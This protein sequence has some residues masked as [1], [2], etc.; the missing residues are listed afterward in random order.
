MESR[1]KV[2]KPVKL[3]ARLAIALADVGFKGGIETGH[4]RARQLARCTYIPEED[5]RTMRAWFARHKHAS[6]PKYKMAEDTWL[7]PLLRSVLRGRRTPRQAAKKASDLSLAMSQWR[8]AIAWLLWGGDAALRWLTVSS[9]GQLRGGGRKLCKRGVDAAKHRFDKWPSAYASGHASQ[10][11]L[12]KI[13]GLDGKKRVDKKYARDTSNQKQEKGITGLSRWFKE[14]WV[15]VCTALDGGTPKPCGRSSAKSTR[16]FPYCR[17][18]VRVTKDT[19]V[20]WKEMER[21][22]LIDACNKKRSDPTKIMPTAKSKSGQRG[23]RG[24]SGKSSAK[25]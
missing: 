6:Y 18:S 3:T 24:K 13:K 20:T 4:R 17:P 7:G 25:R 10:V 11:C 1:L 5:A 21:E 19:P 15:D 23:R 14:K 22:D 16:S 8:G 12:G 9:G 2:P